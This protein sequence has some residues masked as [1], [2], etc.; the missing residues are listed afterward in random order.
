[1]EFLCIEVMQSSVRCQRDQLP[2]KNELLFIKSKT[3]CKNK[4]I[5]FEI[6][7]RSELCAYMVPIM[8]LILKTGY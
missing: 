8:I 4:T 6:I 2:S 5:F 1:M 3:E 7:Q